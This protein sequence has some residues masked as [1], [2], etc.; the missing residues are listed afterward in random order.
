[1]RPV[2]SAPF[3]DPALA[4]RADRL[5]AMEEDLNRRENDLD[6]RAKNMNE[7]LKNGLGPRAPNW[8]RCRPVVYQGI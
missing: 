3:S 1:M 4:S 5:R 7:N 2:S 6:N 8:P